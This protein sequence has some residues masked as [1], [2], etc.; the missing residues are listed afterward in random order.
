[1]EDLVPRQN[2]SSS[3][4]DELVDMLK[5]KNWKVRKEGLDKVKDIVSSAKF[6]TSDLGDLPAAIA[7]R[8]TDMNKNLAVQ[9]TS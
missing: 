8:T 1:M 7:P 4:T 3:I 2:I 6:I 5:D 9:V